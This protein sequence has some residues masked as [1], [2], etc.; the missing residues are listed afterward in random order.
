M[1]S[2]Y[3]FFFLHFPRLRD[4]WLFKWSLKMNIRTFY[5]SLCHSVLS[6]ELHLYVPDY[7]KVA[8][9]YN[10]GAFCVVSCAASEGA[11]L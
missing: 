11:T 2:D 10:I 1:V 6:C 5:Q 8:P 7:Q 4:G 3:L 9:T